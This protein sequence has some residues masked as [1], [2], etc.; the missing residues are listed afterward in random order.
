MKT[1]VVTF[2]VALVAM[3]GPFTTRPWANDAH[4]PEKAASAKKSGKKADKKSGKVKPRQPQ[5]EPAVKPGKSKQSEV[6]NPR[7]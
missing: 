3:A 7:V 4:H 6:R 1:L 2:M 5:E